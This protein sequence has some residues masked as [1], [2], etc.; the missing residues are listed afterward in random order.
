VWSFIQ[1]DDEANTNLLV[2]VLPPR[3]D[4]A[5]VATCGGDSG[6]TVVTCDRSDGQLLEIARGPKKSANG[7]LA[8]LIGRIVRADGSSTRV[9]IH[10]QGDVDFP[11]ELAEQ[12]LRDPAVGWMTTAAVND[13]GERLSD[14]HDEPFLDTLTGNLE[15]V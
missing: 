11:G 7:N 6:F 9:E 4:P 10:A 15:T 14:F 1:L 8:L 13:E 5:P 3:D 2:S 12:V